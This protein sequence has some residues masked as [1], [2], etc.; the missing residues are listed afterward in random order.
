[1][2][3][4]D[5]FDPVRRFKYYSVVSILYALTLF[6]NEYLDLDRDEYSIIDVYTHY[7]VFILLSELAFVICYIPEIQE[8]VIMLGSLVIWRCLSQIPIIRDDFNTLGGTTIRVDVLIIIMV[9]I[10]AIHQMFTGGDIW[11][12]VLLTFAIELINICMLITLDGIDRTHSMAI[13]RWQIFYFA[14]ILFPVKKYHLVYAG[15]FGMLISEIASYGIK[16]P[17][18]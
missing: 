2:R 14:L 8:F 5:N 16:P 15:L 1:M 10:I 11:Q 13:Q 6:I 17:F 7:S 3:T 12:Q 4:N 9:I 18:E